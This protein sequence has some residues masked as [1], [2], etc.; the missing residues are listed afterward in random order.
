MD[1]I[2]QALSELQTEVSQIKSLLLK[3]N[4]S[5]SVYQTEEDLTERFFQECSRLQIDLTD[6]DKW[7]DEEVRNKAA[8]YFGNLMK[9]TNPRA[10]LVKV[11]SQLKP[12]FS[13]RSKVDYGVSPA[14]EGVVEVKPGL[15]LRFDELSITQLYELRAKHKGLSLILCSRSFTELNDMQ[16]AACVH[17]ALED[18]LLK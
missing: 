7:D 1:E 10:Y 2:L 15:F 14:D 13:G 4:Q 17:Y 11:C 18:G 9:I 12:V 16:K 6:A 8:Y 3:G 5:S